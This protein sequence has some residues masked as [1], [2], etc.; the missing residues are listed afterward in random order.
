MKLPAG[1]TLENQEMKLPEGFALEAEPPKPKT[2]LNKVKDFGKSALQNAGEY[3]DYLHTPTAPP[4]SVGDFITRVIPESVSKTTVGAL[5][6]LPRTAVDLS[7]GAGKALNLLTRGKPAEAFKQGME[8]IADLSEGIKQ[9]VGRPLGFYGKEPFKEAWTTDPAGSALALYPGAKTLKRRFR[10][11]A[12]IPQEI[13]AEVPVEVPVETVE[14]KPQVPK[15]FKLEERVAPVEKVV[16]PKGFELETD[17]PDFEPPVSAIKEPTEAAPLPDNVFSRMPDEMIKKQADYGVQ[18]AIDELARRTGVAPPELSPEGKAHRERLLKTPEPVKAEPVAE[19]I[20]TPEIL[21]ANVDELGNWTMPGDTLTSILRN[22]KDQDIIDLMKWSK[23]Q[24]RHVDRNVTGTAASVLRE[25]GVPIDEIKWQ[26]D[27]LS[28]TEAPPTEK[29]STIANEWQK[30]MA[31]ANIEKKPVD[32]VKLMEEVKAEVEGVAPEVKEPWQMTGWEKGTPLDTLPEGLKTAD[33]IV[34]TLPNL[35]PEQTLSLDIS[36]HNVSNKVE[37]NANR[38]SWRKS[39]EENAQAK[40]PILESLREGVTI[41]YRKAE[42]FITLLKNDKAIHEKYLSGEYEIN[43][44]TGNKTWH[45]TWMEAYDK[46]ISEIQTRSVKPETLKAKP[47][48]IA[49]EAVNLSPLFQALDDIK[50][51]GGLSYDALAKDYGKAQMIEL[52]RKRPGLVSKKGKAT[53]D[54]V[55]DIYGFPGGDELL[56]EILNAQSKKKI[57]T[58]LK[59]QFENL[60]YDDIRIAKKG[61]EKTDGI[62]PE[63]LDTGDKVLINDESFTVKG[64]SGDGK[65]ILK[66]GETLFVDPFE[67]LDAEGIKRKIEA[68]KPKPIEQTTELPGL[69][70]KDTFD[71]TSEGAGDVYAGAL[72]EKAPAPR[73]ATID[74]T[75]GIDPTKLKE[76]LTS[77]KEDISETLPGRALKEVVDKLHS[78]EV[79]FNKMGEKGR[80]IYKTADHYEISKNRFLAKEGVEFEKITKGIKIDSP[81]SVKVG[82]ALDGKIPPESLSPKERQVYDWMKSKYQFFLQEAAKSAAGNAEN[83][84]KALNY[85]NR[86]AKPMLRVKD[87]T[88]TEQKYFKGIGKPS[89]DSEYLFK[90]MEKLEKAQDKIDYLHQKWR[91]KT[92]EGVVKAYDILSR[93]IKEYLPHIFDKESLLEGFKV[94]MDVINEKLR[95]ATNDASVKQYKERLKQLED[96]VKVIEGGGFVRYSQLPKNIR[97]R[98]FETRKGAQGYSF[99]AVKAYQSY[100]TG[101]AR[102]IYDE[103]AMQ[104]MTALYK[105]LA[106][107]HKA[108]ADAFLRRYSGMGERGALDEFAN[109]VASFQ[110]MRTLGLNPRSAIVNFTQRV[111]TIAEIGVQYSL[112]GEKM[113]FTEKGKQLFNETGLPEEIP[114]VLYEGSS[115]KM[116]KLRAVVG[117]MF[118]KVE[119][120]NRRHAFLSGYLKGIEKLKMSEADAIQYGIDTVH[121]TQFKYGKV[122]MP[123]AMSSPIGRVGL[124]FWS[125]PIKQLELMHSWAKN[126][127]KKLIYFL[128]MAEG[129]NLTLQQ[130]LDTDLSNA[131]G[132]GFN[133]GEALNAFKDLSKAD[134]REF[135]RHMRLVPATGGG[136]LPSGLGP[137]AMGLKNVAEGIVKG[138]TGKALKKELTPVVY[139]RGKQAVRAI[140]NEQDGKYPLIS[141]NNRPYIHLTAEQLLRRTLGPKTQTESEAFLNYKRKQGLEQQRIEITREIMDKVFT[142]DKD[143]AKRL[144]QETGVVPT[145]QQ[146]KNEM[147]RRKLTP[148]QIQR[149]KKPGKKELYQLQKGHYQG[150]SQ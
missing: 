110:W 148:D 79:V 150:G 61:F 138:E 62:Y 94:E 48:T 98:F 50:A 132:L 131:L 137:T 82:Q 102:K 115:P 109:V 12:A 126:D 139:T 85:A 59:K 80:E 23:E 16:P 19:V 21:K 97:F 104:Q 100:L 113:A 40:M 43:A 96:A 32:P 149:M 134:F 99:D 120:G 86:K 51:S 34:K 92:D 119:M 83:F 1:F 14:V 28:K 74:L 3:Y 30:R 65:V 122:G 7:E 10:R 2:F 26:I 8:P 24:S 88:E 4:L 101:V 144:A 36:L 136:M 66:D 95:T 45:K 129:G 147:I 38:T 6:F 128:A 25:R 135:T 41:P 49:D 33:E 142:G 22:Y 55:A 112:K 125:Y 116:E 81:E 42:Q 76:T 123:L 84:S 17:V 63:T 78:P 90:G 105:D 56:Q 91:E 127:P 44:D 18:G 52:I 58:D 106:P 75:S 64:F 39:L 143:G 53:L 145:F 72:P 117:F 141:E 47:T 27:N 29:F 108:Y 57:N 54:T 20:P 77:L 118:N 107:E 146:F 9:F 124:Q 140:T 130:F 67:K 60:H 70:F 46:L 11:K 69:G 87:L 13:P 68:K 133:W 89:P 103:P 121:K 114:Q 73:Q 35:T 15:G 37:G 71:L 93:E 111:N 31:I 5:E